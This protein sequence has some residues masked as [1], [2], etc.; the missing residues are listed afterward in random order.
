MCIKVITVDRTRI[1]LLI[2]NYQNNFSLITGLSASL[3]SLAT[4]ANTW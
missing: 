4:G 2:M 1:L 3:Q